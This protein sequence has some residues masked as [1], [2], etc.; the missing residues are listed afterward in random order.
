MPNFEKTGREDY[1]R[2]DWMT[3]QELQQILRDDLESTGGEAS[4]VDMILYVS[5]LLAARRKPG[6]ASAAAA[7][8]W[9]S[10]QAHYA[11]E[12]REYESPIPF[13]TAARAKPKGG[14]KW[15]PRAIA[16]AAMVAL[17]IGSTLTAK[18]FGC[19]LWDI[20]VKWTQE[21]F[22]IGYDGDI[23]ESRNPNSTDTQVFLGLQTLIDDYDIEVPLIPTWIPEGYVEVSIKYQDTPKQRQFSALYQKG[24]DMIRIR[25]AD[26]LE[27]N[28][29]EV[30]QSDSLL[31]VY[32]V[33]GVDYYIF[34]NFDQLRAVWINGRYECYIM[35]ALS[36]EELKQMIDSIG[37]DGFI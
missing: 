34:D 36:K 14:M 4:D 9:E 13:E 2:F 33:Q 32:S 8:S 6:E 27:G 26:Y 22:H 31:E 20:I 35:G 19:D 10:F 23:E 17:I 24:E 37:K 16:A 15:W 7:R 25:I 28:P 30:E 11:P 3:T 5:G 21:T 18:A 12:A 1:S 29:A